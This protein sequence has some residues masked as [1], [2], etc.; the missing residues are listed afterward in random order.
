MNYN[1]KYNRIITEMLLV[2][3]NKHK[4]LVYF[5]SVGKWLLIQ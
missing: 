5:K 3:H 4:G 2:G 1:R